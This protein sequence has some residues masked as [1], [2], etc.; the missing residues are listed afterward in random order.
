[1]RFA[2]THVSFRIAELQALSE[3]IDAQLEI[4]ECRDDVRG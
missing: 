3:L 4:L 1:M 2:Q